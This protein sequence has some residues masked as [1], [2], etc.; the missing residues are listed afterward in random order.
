M[1]YVLDCS[2]I[3]DAREFH[4]QLKE[5]LNLP[6][7]YGHNLDAMHDCLTELG[8]PTRLTLDNFSHLKDAL[9][10]YAGKLLYVLHICTEEN[11]SLE[12]SLE[13]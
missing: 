9:G 11:P 10:E 4:R 1:E 8:T 13:N 12:I 3:L 5:I 7:W 2:T 6:D